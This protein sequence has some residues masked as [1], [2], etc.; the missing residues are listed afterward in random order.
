[1]VFIKKNVKTEESVKKERKKKLFPEI[2]PY[3]FFLGETFF[4]TKASF[5][6]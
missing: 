3:T 1:M 5:Q 6:Y 4:D 2:H